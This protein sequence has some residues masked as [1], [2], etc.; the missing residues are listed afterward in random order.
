[1]VLDDATDWDEVHELVTESSCILA[2][3]TLE[4]QHLLG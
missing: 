4:G 1:M 3:K 2:P